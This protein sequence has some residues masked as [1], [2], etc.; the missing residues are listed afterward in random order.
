MSSAQVG[1]VLRHIRKLAAVHT[2]HELPD[3]QLLDRFARHRDE[4]AFTAL[5]QRHGPMVLSVCRNVLHN[6]HDA[7]D[8]FQAAFLL[9]AQK[10]GSIHRQEAVSG[11]LYR[12]AYHAALRARAKVARRKFIEKR[13]IT[14]PSAGPVLDMSLREVRGVLF[15]ELEDLPPQYRA[16]LVLCALEGKSLEEAALLLGWSRGGVKWRLQ[17]GREL[18]RARLRRRGFELPAT[19]AA[20]AFVLD[21]A[22]GPVP[23]ALVDSTLRAAVAAAAG[24]VV[25]A[26]VA[27]LIQG[28]SKAMGIGKW[29]LVTV[30]LLMAILGTAGLG[31]ITLQVLAAWKAE[32]Q[33]EAGAQA[34]SQ[35]I[36][37][38]TPAAGSARDLLTVRG[39]VLSPDSKPVA[40]AKLFLHDSNLGDKDSA[41][42]ATSDVEGRFQLTFSRSALTASGYPVRVMAVEV[43]AMA[44]GYGCD[45][46]TVSEDNAGRELVLRLVKDLPISGRVLDRDGKPV[47]GAK[48]RLGGV[49]AY[50]GKDLTRMLE[51][52]RQEDWSAP[53]LPAKY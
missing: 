7:E 31:R 36:R 46:A 17:R 42:R 4:A 16:P 48:V 25:S 11:W 18:L 29:K 53:L 37:K 44:P 33:K 45:W 26:E 40:G 28:A 5:L 8:A 20:T 12:V 22:S 47:A 32:P 38:G 34:A 6:L 24:G 41:A 35:G 21:A 30:L 2:D 10:A 51:A 19:L 3:Q 23:A 9:L 43:L 13:A 49:G 1:A 50:P 27:D 52:A 15:A 39:R 14:M